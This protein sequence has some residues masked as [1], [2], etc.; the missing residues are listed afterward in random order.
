MLT[1]NCVGVGHWG[2]NLVR[3]LATHSA[4]RVGVVCD[5][6]EERLALVRRN[7]PTIGEFSTDALATVTDPRAD[8]VV[9]AT[10]VKSHYALTKAALE[11]GKHV[12]VEKP[13]CRS[14][15]EGEELVQIAERQGRHLC[16]GHVFLFNNGIRGVRNLIRSGELGRLYYIYST[17]V[18]LGPFRHD[19]NALWDLASHDISIVNYWLDADPLMVTARGDSY[20]NPGVEDVVVANFTYP[21]QVLASIHAGWLN[22]RKVREITVVGEHKMVVWDDMNLSEPIR[23]YNRSVDI[24]REPIYSDNFGTFRMQIRNGDVVLPYIQAAEPLAAECNHFIECIQG[25]REPINSGR[26]GLRVVRALEAADRSMRDRSMLVDILD[27][28]EEPVDEG[29]VLVGA[30]SAGSAELV[31]ARPR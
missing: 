8:A 19:V 24:D 3:L 18:N 9:I 14:S 26:N 7:I 30:A 21:N 6:L 23:I 28:S 12:L 20:L 17:R 16:V 4:A 1:I 31:A 25:K 15:R 22:P 5:K 27:G 11:A 13:L 29:D 10:P 2:P